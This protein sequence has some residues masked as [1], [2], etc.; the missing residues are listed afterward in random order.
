M[1]ERKAKL[2]QVR[3][4]EKEIYNRK[5][6]SSIVSAT[7]KPIGSDSRSKPSSSTAGIPSSYKDRR[8]S[9]DRDRNRDRERRISNTN[10]KNDKSLHILDNE[11]KVNEQSSIVTTPTTTTSISSAINVQDNEHKMVVKVGMR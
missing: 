2:I 11:T 1:E 7:L 6:S 4:K 5:V 8:E 3:I 9:R 10:E